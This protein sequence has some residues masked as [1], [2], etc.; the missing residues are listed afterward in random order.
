MTY[1]ES[2]DFLG[3]TR[4][5][6]MKLG[7]EPMEK[8]ARALGDPQQRLRFIH[9]A[10]TNGKGSTAAFAESCLR[11]GGHRVGLYTS[12]H[13]ISVRERIQI[14][15]Q[16]ISE[17]AFAE[18]MTEVRKAMEKS[19]GLTATFFEILTA[20]ALW[21]FVREKVDWVVWETGMGGRL[22]ATNIVCPEICVITQ[23]GLD[24]QQYL[25][26]SVAEIAVEKAGILKPGIPVITSARGVARQV[27]EKR[28]AELGGR[29][30]VIPNDLEVHDLGFFSGHQRARIDGVD[31]DLGLLGSH[32]VENAACA[33]AALRAMRA[34]PDEA[35]AQGL[36]LAHWPGRF[37]IISRDP[38][39][40]LDGA[41][42]PDGAVRLAGTWAALLA[43]M[44]LSGPARTTHLVFGAVTDK[45]VEKVAR[46][47]KPLAEEVSLVRLR[48]ERSC[49][50]RGLMPYFPGIE[51]QLYNSVADWWH[52]NWRASDVPMLIAGSLFLAGEVLALREGRAED[53]D[54]NERLGKSLTR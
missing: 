39:V 12:P 13:L 53:Y 46:V 23:I 42:N 40:V 20:V 34:V 36:A 4:R 22:D 18:G 21:Y 45:D 43:S 26:N 1:R 2:L 10:G 47:L 19:L 24:H 35:L 7:L 3:G 37:E 54:L 15:R 48:N 49:D 32:Q 41:H 14:D 51:P 50:P 16:E 29:V 8:M 52:S 11:A 31:Y 30:T 28:A 27:V 33:V 38:L 17:K 6:G 44:K 5:F 9:I 25:G